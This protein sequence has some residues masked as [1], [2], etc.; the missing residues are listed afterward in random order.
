VL[1]RSRKR[2]RRPSISCFGL[3]LGHGSEVTNVWAE[4]AWDAVVLCCE[5]LF[6][7]ENIAAIFAVS[8]RDQQFC[9]SRISSADEQSAA[10]ANL[11]TKIQGD[12]AFHNQ[13]EQAGV[14]GARIVN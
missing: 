8:S 9:T 10:L 1:S 5:A 14:G 11:A 13:A 3:G 7:F 2:F 4:V 6:D 12:H